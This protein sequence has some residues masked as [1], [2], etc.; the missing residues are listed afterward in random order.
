MT[1]AAMGRIVAGGAHA[2]APPWGPPGAFG[3]ALMRTRLSLRGGKVRGTWGEK[4]AA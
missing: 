3:E 1:L 2:P 4:H